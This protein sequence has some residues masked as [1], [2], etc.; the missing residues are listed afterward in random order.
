MEKE[1]YVLDFEQYLGIFDVAYALFGD[2]PGAD[3]SLAKS[4]G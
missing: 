2:D 4:W 1:P 3:L